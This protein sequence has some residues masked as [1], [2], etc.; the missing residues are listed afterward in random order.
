[1]RTASTTAGD[2]VHIRNPVGGT[3]DSPGI[4]PFVYWAQTES[5]ISLRVDIR[6]VKDPKI[7]IEDSK[8]SFDA[9]GEG[10]RGECE[11]HFELDLPHDICPKKSTFRVLDRDITIHLQKKE[12]G[13]WSKV[14]TTHRKPAWLKVDFDRWKSPDDDEPELEPNIMKDYPNMM[15]SLRTEEFGYKVESLRKVYLFL[16]NLFQFVGYLY[17][18]S[19]LTIRYLKDGQEATHKAFDLVGFTMC[20]C[21]IL[22]MLEIAH[23]V[24]GFTKTSIPMSIMQIMGRN[25]ILFGTINPEVRLHS[26]SFIFFLFYIWALADIIRYPFYMMQMYNVKPYLMTWLRYSC[27]IPLYPMGILSECVIIFNAITFFEETQK[28][29]LLLP[30]SLNATFYFP[31]LMRIYL[32]F[33]VFPATSFIIKSMWRGRKKVLGTPKIVK[34]KD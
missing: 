5:S 23:A 17:I 13:W 19:V 29:S 28:F 34:V 30:N 22:Q 33:G 15:D 20:Y 24:F 21:Q 25:V 16:Y 4:S 10:A 7:N 2:W 9:V 8:V 3:P 6:N 31:A 32:L 18:V 1:M 26:H 14:T 12:N 27:W 11:Y